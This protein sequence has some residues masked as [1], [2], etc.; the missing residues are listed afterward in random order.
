MT[1]KQGHL[2]LELQCYL[3]KF[4]TIKFRHFSRAAQTNYIAEK[5]KLADQS[6]LADTQEH[7]FLLMV[8]CSLWFDSDTERE[9]ERA[10]MD[11]RVFFWQL[12]T[13]VTF[14]ADSSM[15]EPQE[16]REGY[17]VKKVRITTWKLPESSYHCLCEHRASLK[18]W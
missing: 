11:K 9:R 12:L 14:A 4:N 13:R 6:L 2:L 8:R 17:L 5:R 1:R 15:M 3:F 7:N 10:D 18:Y 16:I